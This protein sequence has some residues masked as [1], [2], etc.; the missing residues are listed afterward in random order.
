MLVVQCRVRTAE[1]TGENSMDLTAGRE[2]ETVTGAIAPRD[3]FL[4]CLLGGAV[5]DALGAAVEFQSRA[6]IRETFGPDGITDYAPIYGGLGRLTDDT[7]MTLFTAAGLR[8]AWV[9]SCL[10]GVT[11]LSALRA[12]R[13]DDGFAQ[14][15]LGGI[16]LILPANRGTLSPTATHS[17]GMTSVPGGSGYAWSEGRPPMVRHRPDIHPRL[18]FSGAECSLLLHEEAFVPDSSSDPTFK[19]R[20]EA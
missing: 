6:A 4:G 20:L 5:G 3:R 8:R 19:G 14:N 11:S 18:R 2:T 17:T 15:D 10:R 16:R 1:D 13:P 9:R 12:T 7:Q